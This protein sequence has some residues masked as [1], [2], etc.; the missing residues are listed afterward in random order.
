M[1]NNDLLILLQN[2]I[3][4]GVSQSEIAKRI[5]CSPATI[6][7]INSEKYGGDPSIILSLFEEIYGNREVSC[8]ILG[9]ISITRCATNRRMKFSGSNPVRVRLCKACPSCDNNR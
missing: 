4:E 2:T 9:T 3:A 8:P 7:Q 6:S 1:T 5:G